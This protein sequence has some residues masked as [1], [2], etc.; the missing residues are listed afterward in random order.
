MNKLTHRLYDWLLDLLTTES[1]PP[2][3]EPSLATR[4]ELTPTSPADQSLMHQGL[5]G[6]VDPPMDPFR[7]EDTHYD[8]HRVVMYDEHASLEADRYWIEPSDHSTWSSWD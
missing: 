8:D 7:H 1:L 5:A 3:I 6:E 2:L 4:D